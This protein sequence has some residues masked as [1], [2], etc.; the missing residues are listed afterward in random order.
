MKEARFN[1]EEVELK[2]LK[3]ELLTAIERLEAMDRV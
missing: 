3:G 1:T 2:A